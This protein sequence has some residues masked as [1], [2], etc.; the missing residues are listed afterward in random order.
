MFQFFFFSMNYIIYKT[1]L[2]HW[3]L[4]FL[5]INT[6]SL[7][8]NW[9]KEADVYTDIIKLSF[10]RCISCHYYREDRSE[11]QM[12]QRVNI[13]YRIEGEDFSCK[14]KKGTLVRNIMMRVSWMFLHVAIAWYYL[15]KNVLSPWLPRELIFIMKRN[16]GT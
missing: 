7:E 4:I 10:R 3:S 16:S 9:R 11:R 1:N 14:K 8:T 5:I 6:D 12:C 15:T 2:L 13:F